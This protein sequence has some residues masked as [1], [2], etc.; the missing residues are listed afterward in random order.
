MFSLIKIEKYSLIQVV[1][2]AYLKDGYPIRPFFPKTSKDF[3]EFAQ[4][5]DVKGN[6]E[7]SQK[8]LLKAIQMGN[9][10]AFLSKIEAPLTGQFGY[11]YDPQKA[12]LDLMHLSDTKHRFR[13]TIM[14]RIHRWRQINWEVEIEVDFYKS[15]TLQIVEQTMVNYEHL[16]LANIINQACFC[17]IKVLTKLVLI[18][19]VENCIVCS[20]YKYNC[21]Q[22]KHQHCQKGDCEQHCK[23]C[24][25]KKESFKNKTS[26]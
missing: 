10:Y 4:E 17:Q 26:F 5:E 2:K 21:F 14:N 20:A 1:Y 8:F 18:Y 24:S 22:W 12:I 9:R 3:Y 15:K 16:F 23:L 25:K 13:K 7:K 19:L 6:I 11:K